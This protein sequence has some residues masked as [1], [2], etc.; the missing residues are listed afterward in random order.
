MKTKTVVQDNESAYLKWLEDLKIEISRNRQRA[1]L[2]VNEIAMQTYWTIGKDIVEKEKKFKWGT[3]FMNRLSR[4]LSGHFN[5]I[6]GFS[7]RNLY[8]IRQ[9]YLFYSKDSEFVPQSAAQIPWGHNRLIISKVKDVNEALWYAGATAK[10]GWARDILELKI[11]KKEYQ[12]SG[13]AI[14]NF[15]STLQLPLSGLARETL[16][17]PYNFDFLGLEDEAQEREIEKGLVG[18]IADF[19]LELG[20]GFAFIGNQYKLIVNDQEYFLDLLF[21][22]MTLRCYV[23]IELK[24]VKFKPEF[25]GK[26]NFY[27]SAVDSQLRNSNDN[28]S[29]GLILCRSKNSLEVEYALRDINKPIGVSEY[30]LTDDLPVDYIKTL[31]TIAEIENELKNRLDHKP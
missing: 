31:P 25:S 30:L 5:D 10:N 16:K 15:N 6:K 11:K 13:K 9:W 29:I 28:P 18:K 23:I 17:D 12:R 2:S 19:I 7:R 14:T 4:D 26:M 27:L 8:A 20:K 24:S 21:Y 22:H 1:A 3:A